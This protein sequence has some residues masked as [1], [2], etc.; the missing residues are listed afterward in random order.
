MPRSGSPKR[1]P[2]ARLLAEEVKL[3][4]TSALLLCLSRDLRMAYILV[5]IVGLAGPQA[6]AIL[7]ID[8]VLFRKRLSLARKQVRSFLAP[9]CGHLDKK[10]PC[11]CHKQIG[12]DL[13]VGWIVRG[14]LRY[15]K[16]GQTAA[17][18]SLDATFDDIADL[19]ATHLAHD[20]SS[21][22]K[23]SLRARLTAIDEVQ[24][25]EDP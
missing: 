13:E 21:A 22:W 23:A 11:R 8:P 5:E 20:S 25:E 3:S 4:C 12:Y 24:V 1:S 10:N 7:E 15:A 6:A 14:Q 16:E 19:Y 18:Q 9:R 2:D 17:M